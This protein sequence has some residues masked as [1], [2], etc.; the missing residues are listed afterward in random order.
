MIDI[1]A[2]CHDGRMGEA[3]DPG[4]LLRDLTGM[5]PEDIGV[6]LAVLI[7]CISEEEWSAGWL[8]GIEGTCRAWADGMAAVGAPSQPDEVVEA[9][10]RAREALGGGWVAWC[11]AGDEDNWGICLLTAEE[12]AAW[13]APL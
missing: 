11:H 13:E 12:W 8:I 5:S 4:P 10:R 7:S 6:E 9:L 3:V 2:R 1:D